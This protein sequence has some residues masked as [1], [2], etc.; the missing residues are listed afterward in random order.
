MASSENRLSR[1]SLSALVIGSMIGAGIFSLPR[2]FAVATGPFGAIIAKVVPIFIFIVILAFAFKGG[3]SHSNFWG[4]A[5]MPEANLF[6]QIHKTMLVTVFVF[7]GIEGVSVYSRYAKKRSDVGAAT[8]IGFVAV[9]ATMMLVT[10]LS[11]SVLPRADI[12]AMLEAVVGHWDAVFIS[13][14]LLV[15][16]LG[17]YLAWAL[18]CAEVLFTAAKTRDMPKLFAHK[19]ANKVP[20]ATLWLTNIIVQLFVL[21]I[22]FSRDAFSLM[23][24]LTS[25]MTLVGAELGRG[26]GGGHCMTCPIIRDAVDY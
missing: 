9:T 10:L 8:R 25:S 16:V 19:N 11:Y 7:I 21:S 23:L 4:G 2:T 22:Y 26:R 18:I 14:G 15:S 6:E 12:A 20:S 13:L 17:A 1:L 5:G 3:L 24:N